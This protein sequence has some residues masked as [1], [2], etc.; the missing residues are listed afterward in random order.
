MPELGVL[1]QMLPGLRAS[2]QSNPV[3]NAKRFLHNKSCSPSLRPCV[4]ASQAA[5]DNSRSPRRFDT[6][7]D[8]GFGRE[9]RQAWLGSG[10]PCSAHMVARHQGIGAGHTVQRGP[11]DCS[12]AHTAHAG[13]PSSLSS[14]RP[15]SK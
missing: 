15:R 4:Q 7:E 6:G 12:L 1:S 10:S 11:L 13:P 2:T 9:A 5:V 8:M 3:T 14:I